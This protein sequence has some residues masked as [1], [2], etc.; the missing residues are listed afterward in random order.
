MAAR[1]EAAIAALP[2]RQKAALSLCY[3]EELSC[4]EAAGVLGVSISTM[5]SLLVRARRTV[6]ARLDLPEKARSK[7]K[8]K[9]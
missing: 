1:A 5:E 9:P 2:D 7:G 3:Y 6:R 8:A 4:A